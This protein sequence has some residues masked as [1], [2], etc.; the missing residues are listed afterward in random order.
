MP[1][2]KLEPLL[3]HKVFRWASG[4]SALVATALLALGALMADPSMR[5]AHSGLAMAFVVTSL[6]AG[7]AGMRYGKQSNTKGL[8]GHGL[9]VFGVGLLQFALGE[10]GVTMLHMV[11]GVLVVGGAV[12]FFM[13]SLKQPS[14]VTAADGDAA[15]TT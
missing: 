5:P 9:G 2:T 7:L 14:V 4:V 12:T 6:L 13:M 1:F 15:T 10:L 3:S 8:T 11:L